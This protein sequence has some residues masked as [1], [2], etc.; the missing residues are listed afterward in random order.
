VASHSAKEIAEVVA[1]SFPDT[2]VELLTT[3][4]QRY[5]DINAWRDNPVL[6][7]RAFD[8]LQKVMTSAGE[9]SKSA[10][11]DIVVNN[12]FAEKVISE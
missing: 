1:P 11:H 10:P 12:T 7:Q 3:V 9:L 2:D 4:A 8:L 5:K 6:D